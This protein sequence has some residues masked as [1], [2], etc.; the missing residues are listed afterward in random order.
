MTDDE[1][2]ALVAS[3]AV[4]QAKTDTELNKLAVAQAQTDIELNKLAVAQA[5][6]D[7]ELKALFAGIAASQQETDRKFQET[8]RKFQETEQQ[9]RETEQQIRET[10]R[11]LRQQ[12]KELNQQIGGLSDK[13]GGMTEGLAWPAMSRILT[14]EFGMEFITPRVKVRKGGETMELDVFGYANSSRNEAWIVEIKSHLRP[15]SIE[16]FKTIMARFRR[17][18]PEHQDK[19]LYGMFAVIDAS[20]EMRQQALEAGFMLARIHEEEFVL[21]SPRDFQPKSW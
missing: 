5:Q 21:E 8:D 16:Q 15:Q 11:Q 19:K 4:A 13:F 20:T 9:I 7:A 3:L 6:T 2:K 12:M 1:L 10:D 17:F 14:E 18:F